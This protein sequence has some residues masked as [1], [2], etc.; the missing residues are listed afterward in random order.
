M[1]DTNIFLS[2]NNPGEPES[3]N[4]RKILDRT[5][6]GQLHAHVSVV[7]LAEIRAGFREQEVPALF[8]P[9][10]SH[11]QS[12]KNYTIEAID[13]GT[14]LAAGDLRELLGLPLPDALILATALNASVDCVVSNDE[15]LLKV[16][17][18]VR[19]RSSADVGV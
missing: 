10:L 4:C 2:A 11:L 14:A 9:F 15:K 3:E 6:A 5:D 16:K 13:L 1:L 12:S 8:T 17:S 19:V 18:R 7:T